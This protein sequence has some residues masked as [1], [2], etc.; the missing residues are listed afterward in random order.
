MENKSIEELNA[1]VEQENNDAIY[2]LARR[3]YYGNG[4]EKIMKKRLKD[5]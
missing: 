3:N 4:I 5:T 1:L 2:E